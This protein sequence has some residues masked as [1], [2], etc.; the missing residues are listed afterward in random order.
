MTASIEDLTPSTW[1]VLLVISTVGTVQTRP[2]PSPFVDRENRD[3]RPRITSKHFLSSGVKSPE[4]TEYGV[5]VLYK[6]KAGPGSLQ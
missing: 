3:A 2:P 4:P 6:V 5:I 1:L